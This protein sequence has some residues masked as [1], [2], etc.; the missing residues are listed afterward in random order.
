MNKGRYFSSVSKTLLTIFNLLIIGMA[1]CMVSMR[2]VSRCSFLAANGMQ[3]GLGLYVSGKA[4]HDNPSS[5]SF[6][7]A[8]NA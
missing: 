4:I 5:A 7:C 3:C 6:S 8:N 1:G 2:L